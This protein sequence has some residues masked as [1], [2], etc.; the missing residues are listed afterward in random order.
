MLSPGA[1][2]SWWDKVLT[3]KPSERPWPQDTLTPEF[4]PLEKRRSLWASAC[5][6]T[7]VEALGHLREGLRI[8][9]WGG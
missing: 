1:T 6:R 3:P 8:R 9:M 4:Q 5:F 2:R 7:I